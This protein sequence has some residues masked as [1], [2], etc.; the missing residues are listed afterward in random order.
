MSAA[1]AARWSRTSRPRWSRSTANARAWM[2]MRGYAG[3]RI[4]APKIATCWM[5]GRAADAI[6]QLVVP[7]KAGT[8]NHRCLLLR[9]S[10]APASLNNSRWWLW[11]LLSQGRRVICIRLRRLRRLPIRMLRDRIDTL[12]PQRRRHQHGGGLGGGRRHFWIAGGRHDRAQRAQALRKR[13]RD[14]LGDHAAYRSADQ[15]RRLDAERIHQPRHI[16]RQVEQSVGRGDRDLQE[17]LLE[18]F[19][20]GQA[21][22]ARKLAGF[23]DVAIVEPDDAKSARR[24]LGAE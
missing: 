20:R 18:Q 13:D 15:M 24:E 10:A 21:L 7:A 12:R 9:P 6:S 1:P 5:C 23:A 3:S 8:P 11:L 19:E 22:A 17:P 2:R 16:L 14:L 4:W